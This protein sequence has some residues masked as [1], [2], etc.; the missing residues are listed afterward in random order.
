MPGIQLF[1]P[2]YRKEECLQEIGKCFDA[3]WTGLGF[4]TVEF[5]TAWKEYTGYK[6]AHFLNSATSALHIAVALLKKKYSWSDGD[7]II[8][9]PIT[10]VSTN[11]AVLYNN[12]TPVF[13]D[14]DKFVCLDPEDV[15]RKITSKTRA[16]MFMTFGGSIGQFSAIKDIATRYSLSIIL[17]A[18]HA[19]GTRLNGSIF[20]PG[21]ADMVCYSFHSV[22]NLPIADGGMLCCDNTDM[23]THARKMS[24]LGISKDTY[25]R[26]SKEGYSWRYDV[27]ETG[28]KSHGNS[29]LA[30][31]GLVQLRYLDTDNAYRRQIR[32][33]YLQG[34]ES[35]STVKGMVVP[36]DNVVKPVMV[37]LG[38]ETSSH[39]FCIRCVKRDC[40]LDYLRKNDIYPGV[41]YQS[42]LDY[43]MYHASYDTCPN[44]TIIAKE[45]L[46]LP[47]HLELT[48]KDVDKICSIINIFQ[49]KGCE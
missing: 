35:P 20:G 38:C 13:A 9:T 32:D 42:N 23:D 14:V 46:S 49:H 45:I 2:V 15:E 7:E 48:K 11:H 1:V 30:A 4:K 5:E 44:A 37:P 25:S 17:D 8:T 22:K 34:I 16:I 47:M 24:W 28:F 18:A 12:L 43:P 29:V 27:N 36:H 33:W 26:T 21:V 19:A 31:I 10:F 39:L 40:L 3:H 6:Y 41:H